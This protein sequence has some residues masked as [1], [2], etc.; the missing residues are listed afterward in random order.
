M[1]H[2]ET[3][4]SSFAEQIEL[5]NWL[6]EMVS[7]KVRTLSAEE[8]IGNPEH[9][10]YPI[11]KGRE[12]M[13]A[14]EFRGVQG[15]AFTDMMGDFIGPLKEVAWLELANNFERAVFWPA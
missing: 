1:D 8:A 5:E 14:A 13:M 9:R 3:L 12:K 10:D 2:F 6:D 7:I 15:Q 11:I 4:R